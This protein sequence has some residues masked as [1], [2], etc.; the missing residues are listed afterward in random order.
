MTTQN[1]RKIILE[2]LEGLTEVGPGGR[3]FSKRYH[4]LDPS[5]TLDVARAQADSTGLTKKPM[6]ALMRR[7]KF[8]LGVKDAKEFA[9]AIMQLADLAENGKMPLNLQ[10]TLSAALWELATRKGIDAQ[11]EEILKGDTVI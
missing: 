6:A 8:N 9:R 3:G 5:F 7:R 2:E 4:D 10:G 11:V 1:L